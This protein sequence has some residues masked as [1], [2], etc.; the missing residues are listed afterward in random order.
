MINLP[1]KKTLVSVI[2]L[3]SFL[4]VSL[5]G[6]AA[7]PKALDNRELAEAANTDETA[8]LP[9]HLDSAQIDSIVAKLNDAQVRRLLINELKEEAASEAA[10]EQTEK[11]A[12]GLA[13][14]INRLKTKEAL[15]R[16][17]L[18]FLQSGASAAPDD[19]PKVFAQFLAGGGTLDFF[20][21]LLSVIILFAVSLTIEFVF[22]RYTGKA[23]QN[24][25]T[26]PPINWRVKMGRLALRSLLDF[27]SI[28]VF[29]LATLAL[30]FIFIEKA[31]GQRLVVITYLAAFLIVMGVQM[32]SRFLLA[33]TAPALRYFPLD[34]DTALYIHKWVMRITVVGAFG[35]LTC[36]LIRLHQ[37]SEASH[38]ILV[39]MVGLVLAMMISV[40]ILQ[41]RKP[42]A[43]ALRKD[44]PDF[45]LRAQVASIWHYLAIISVFFLWAVWLI[46]LL[47]FGTRAEFP[48][49]ETLLSIPLFF[50]LDW[51]LQSF[52]NVIFGIV[53]TP[54]DIQA[55]IKSATSTGQ[56]ST[57]PAESNIPTVTAEADPAKLGGRLNIMR[58]HRVLRHGLRIL[59]AAFIIFWLMD[60]WGIDLKIGKAVA[61]AVFNI[62]VA[63]LLCYVAWEVINSL[64]ERRL[65]Q[66]MPAADED[67]EEGGSGGSRVGTLLVLLRKFLLAVLFVMVTLII[68]S[69][70]GVNIGPLI[71]GAGVIGLA[72]GFGAQTLVKDII[73][74]VFF[75]ID[76]AFRVGDYVETGAMKGMVEHIS[77]RSLR[78][79]HPRGMV[80]TIP[81]GA[82][83]SVTNLSR[84]YIITKLDIRVRY[85]T[86]VQK[87][88]KIIKR[89]NS[90]IKSDE[91]MG[92]VLLDDIKSQ[93]VREMDD[94]AMIMRVKFKT[95]PGEQFVIRREVYRRI[96]EAFGE[97]GIEFA[98][99]N[100]TVYLPKEGAQPKSG[101]G[102]GEKPA[103]SES[104][105]KKIIE[106]GAAAAIAAAQA[107]ED[108][109]K[110]KK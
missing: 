65:K 52:L 79:R 8:Q 25:E 110:D 102:Q 20:K 83:G 99:R 101:E 80:H 87:V 91:E 62:L 30:S 40:M 42:V 93:G 15:I 100:V 28:C 33:P 88:K 23:R 37:I 59:L 2:G 85:D 41:K 49:I 12:G 66:E 64:I 92:P 98:H 105:D 38:L 71:A 73:S 56:G 26:T 21:I 108:Q 106:T 47:L 75:L 51:I 97:A 72:I 17:R 67:M 69:S 19:L 70:L 13:G 3:S 27:G 78:L 18:R 104:P 68:L 81:F 55:A 77:L 96:Q 53:Q 48:A 39:A 107:E 84:D 94:S 54:H 22:R 11:A 24:I 45:K 14:F 63:G 31:G 9:D 109:K 46:D 60:L 50:I 6:Y 74:G 58:F 43:E 90:E 82:I 7:D 34:D 86:D 10:K 32:V 44:S 4:F 57:A 89:I 29:A 103:A 5:T 76:D 16:E 1:F 61:G 36:G 35:W 95:I